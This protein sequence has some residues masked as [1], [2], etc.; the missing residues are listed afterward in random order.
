M[1][2]MKNLLMMFLILTLIFP[3]NSRAQDDS[4]TV[5][6]V[7]GGLLAIGSGIAAYEQLKEQ[8]ELKAVEE[9]LSA[10]PEL[11]NF[12]LKTST[13]KGTKAKDISSVGVVTYE[14]TD[15]DKGKRYVLF[16]FLSSGWTNQYG[17]DFN[18]VRWKLFDN[19]EWNNLMKAFVETASRKKISLESV[20][21]SKF[22]A[23]GLKNG[24][25]YV[26]EF[27]KLSGDVYSILDYSDDFKVVF[28]EGSLGLYL[29]EMMGDN[30][31]MRRG[32]VRG[33]L[34]QIKRKAL[35]KAHAHLN[36]HE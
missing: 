3:V 10:Y 2:I 13:L 27:A 29:K 12:E 23:K 26:I 6:A 8:L 28:N 36:Y 1:L 7:A 30:K 16:S 33:D 11:K 19:L 15:F 25:F 17:L 9:I 4:A 14:I 5:A 31:D 22:G 20:A 34:V 18:K 24:R 21:S 32:G 35:S